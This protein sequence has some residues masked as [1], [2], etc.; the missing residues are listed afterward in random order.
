MISSASSHIQV[1][2]KD[3][4]CTKVSLVQTSLP[5]IT[6]AQ[7]MKLG[8]LTPSPTS[9]KRGRSSILKESRGHY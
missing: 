9:E 3:H 2:Q 4:N 8:G 7:G 5:T 6:V 1:Q